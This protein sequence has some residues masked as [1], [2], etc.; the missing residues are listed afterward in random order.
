MPSI[1]SSRSPVRARTDIAALTGSLTTNVS[2]AARI[3]KPIILDPALL[4]VV[5]GIAFLAITS[6][7]LWGVSVTVNVMP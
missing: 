7:S 5:R 2:N 4:P 3:S 1:A 6:S